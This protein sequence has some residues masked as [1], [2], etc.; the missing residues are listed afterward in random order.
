MNRTLRILAFV[1]LAVVAACWV[2]MFG[3]AMVE[4]WLERRPPEPPSILSGSSQ[5]SGI[6]GTVVLTGGV[7]GSTLGAWAAPITTCVRCSRA[8]VNGSVKVYRPGREWSEAPGSLAFHGCL[9][10]L[11]ETLD[12]AEDQAAKHKRSGH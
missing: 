8:S 11:C 4:S 3:L 5:P 6:S 2:A 10:C 7:A 12:Y 1:L 9:E